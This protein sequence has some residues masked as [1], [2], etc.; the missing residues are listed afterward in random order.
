[1]PINDALQL[2]YALVQLKARREHRAHGSDQILGSHL[3]T[4]LRREQADVR[5][6]VGFENPAELRRGVSADPLQVP[7]GQS[8][9]G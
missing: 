5:G 6:T 1:M 2:A 4:I 9:V 8:L 7:F 3:V